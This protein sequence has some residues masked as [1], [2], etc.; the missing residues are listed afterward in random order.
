MKLTLHTASVTAMVTA[1][2]SR[3]ASGVQVCV[4]ARE[5][6]LTTTIKSNTNTP[7]RADA[8]FFL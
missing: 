1:N 7:T 2:V 6:V 8:Y 3:L 5:A 4:V